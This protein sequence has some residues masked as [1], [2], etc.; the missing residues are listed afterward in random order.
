MTSPQPQP[1]NEYA[2][3]R[4]NGDGQE[5]TKLDMLLAEFDA[6]KDAADETKKQLDNITK[7]IKAE[8]TAGVTKPD[9][10]PYEAYNLATPELRQ[11]LRL[12]WTVSHRVDTTALRAAHPKIAEQFTR[13]SG[14]WVLKRVK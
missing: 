12:A 8:L 9:G 13:A 3:V 7:L 2:Y 11:P 10:S 4:A 5:P 1:V 6:L 14:T